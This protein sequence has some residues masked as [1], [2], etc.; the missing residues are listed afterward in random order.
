ME[1]MKNGD[2]IN[3]SNKA[4]RPSDLGGHVVPDIS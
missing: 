3:P 4:F 1:S 2:G